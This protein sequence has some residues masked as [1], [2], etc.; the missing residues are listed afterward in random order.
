MLCGVKFRTNISR[1]QF[2][3]LSQIIDFNKNVSSISKRERRV[4]DQCRTWIREGKAIDG[5]FHVVLRK[6]SDAEYELIGRGSIHKCFHGN[7]SGGFTGIEVM[8]ALESL[9][10][11]LKIDP[12]QTQVQYLE[13][14]INV[15]VWFNVYDYL[16]SNLIYHKN[17]YRRKDEELH[18]GFV[19]AYDDDKLIKVYEKNLNVLRFECRYQA[20]LKEF[21]IKTL[22]DIHKFSINCMA[23]ALKK[24]W[25]DIVLTNG[26][27]LKDKLMP[28]PDRIKLLE[29]T[30]EKFQIDYKARLEGASATTKDQMRQE[31]HRSKKECLNIINQFGDGGHN[32]IADLIALMI[33]D[34][35]GSF[36]M[37]P[38]HVSRRC[39]GAGDVTSKI[40]SEDNIAA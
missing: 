20:K 32:K 29:F 24:E 35:N 18:R 37:M 36:E 38:C 39:L 33:S 19:F 34:F 22:A 3:Y 30:N 12:F 4:D 21:G 2:I 5:N 16:L 40:I 1:K 17:K 7:N 10:N 27:N 9:W 11:F 13:I 31:R 28:E 25:N 15:P 14:G 8:T 6:R 23:D 26:I